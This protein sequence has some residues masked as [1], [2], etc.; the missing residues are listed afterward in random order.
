[1]L[2]LFPANA[3]AEFF[4]N[5][6]TPKQRITDIIKFKAEL[7]EHL[8]KA[9]ELRNKTAI[10]NSIDQFM[11]A[12]KTN[13][14][15]FLYNIEEDGDEKN[16]NLYLTVYYDSYKFESFNLICWPLLNTIGLNVSDEMKG[17]LQES[18]K[19]NLLKGE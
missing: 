4:N 8:G 7:T 10:K 2:L 19:R 6:I 17:Q 16:F 11:V 12:N 14:K 15:P 1:M 3:K 13:Y 5:V 18:G 9:L